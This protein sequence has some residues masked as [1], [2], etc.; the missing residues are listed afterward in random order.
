MSTYK[1]I[2]G[3]TN[4]LVNLLSDRMVEPSTVTAAPPDV[5]VDQVNT[6]RLNLYL[7]HLSENPY[8]KNQEIPGEGNPGAYGNPSLSLNLH[9]IVTAFATTDTGVDSDIIAQRVL[10]DAMRV[11]HDF[12]LI[13]ANLLDK[14]G[15]PV[16]DTSLLDEYEQIKVTLQPKSLE[17]ISKIWTAL[18]RVNFRRSATYEACVVQ[19]ESQQ[20]RSI[21]L[22]VRRNRVYALTMQSPQIQ[23]IY[24]QP[25][26]L[27]AKI[28]AAQE[29]ETLRLIGYNFN[30]PNTTVVMDAV[31]AAITNQLNNQMDVVVPTGKLQAGIHSLQVLQAVMLTE[32][33]GKPPV[34]RGGFSSNAVGFQ[35]IPKIVTGPNNISGTVKVT[36]QPAVTTEQQVSLLLG[37]FVVPQP[38]M[39]PGSPPT[40]NLQFPLP[41]PPQ[42]PIPA[43]TYLARVRI[44][45]AESRLQVDLNPVSPTYLQYIGPTVP[46]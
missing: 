42:S 22:P 1:A 37:D 33:Q 26:L 3:V 30:L 34:Q 16:L 40:S 17:E 15:Q 21:G 39:A 36:V 8:L 44:D 38:P 12:S 28:A 10:G 13:P 23:E 2:A 20:P 27:G 32:F 46:V 41:Q 45:G 4:T 29:G 43:G 31:Q 6:A 35:L 24:L 14:S 7:Y 25:P 9:Y 18:P 11:M 19:I 5:Q